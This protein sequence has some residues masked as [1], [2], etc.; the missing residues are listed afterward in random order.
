MCPLVK[1]VHFQ[2]ARTGVDLEI[3]E[4][5]GYGN[6]RRIKSQCPWG[7]RNKQQNPTEQGKNEVFAS[8]AS[9]DSKGFRLLVHNIFFLNCY[10]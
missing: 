1:T 9:G 2:R 3:G 7:L 4:T 5:S 8:Q 6:S 10:P